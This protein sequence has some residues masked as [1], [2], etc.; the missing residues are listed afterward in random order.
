[1]RTL[2]SIALCSCLIASG[3]ADTNGGLWSH[4]AVSIWSGSTDVIPSPDGQSRLS[5]DRHEIQN[6]TKRTR[7]PSMRTV[8]CTTRRLGRGLM[9][10]PWSADS[11]A[12]FVRYSDGGNVGTYNLK[13]V[14]VSS[15]GLRIIEPVPN[16]RKLF[17]PICFEPEHPNVAASEGRGTTRRSC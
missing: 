4:S 3:A 9:Q 14:Y 12:F 6:R 16:G 13:I 11:Q 10:R 7:L 8:A 17:A 1:M 2:L 15:T 5:Y